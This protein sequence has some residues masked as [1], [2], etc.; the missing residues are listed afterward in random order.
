MHRAGAQRTTEYT[1][2]LRVVFQFAVAT[3]S[4]GKK[5]IVLLDL[6][7]ENEISPFGSISDI[8]ELA[9]ITTVGN[10]M[11]EST[12]RIALSRS[13]CSCI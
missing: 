8:M 9:V 6:S 10:P 11:G 5:V 4:S 3:D 7:L 12:G 2:W 1:T 13:M